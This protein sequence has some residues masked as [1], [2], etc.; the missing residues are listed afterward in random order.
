MELADTHALGA[1]AARCESSNLSV[2]TKV[3]GTKEKKERRKMNKRV[4]P[5]RLQRMKELGKECFDAACKVYP[6]LSL[7]ESFKKKDHFFAE[8]SEEYRKNL[9]KLPNIVLEDIILAYEKNQFGREES[10]VYAVRTELARRAIMG[11]YVPVK[12]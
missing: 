8:R 11:E 7:D 10:T 9:C 2:G 1:C 3:M 6:Q 4:S 12:P 5:K